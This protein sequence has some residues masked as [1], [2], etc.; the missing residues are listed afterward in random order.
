MAR[1]LQTDIYLD[2]MKGKPMAMV[3][4]D[5][6]VSD[7]FSVVVYNIY[8]AVNKKFYLYLDCYIPEETLVNHPNAELYKIWI[9]AGWMH[10]C[11]GAVID[12]KVIVRDIL[13]RSK[14]MKIKQIG[15]DAYKSQEIVNLLASA[16]SAN[17]A[18]PE[19]ILKPVP[20]NY[21]SFTSPVETFEMAAKSNPPR[22]AMDMNP[23]WPYCFGNCYLDIDKMEN[24]KPLKRMANC[25]IDAAI[26]ALMTFW[27]YN[28]YEF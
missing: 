12:G 16:I 24:K 2:A 22:V 9:N 18:A 17:G 4:L 26:G 10:V 11:E 14:L 19:K 21:A 13:R 8:S 15:Y 6:S 25:K 23:I 3:A 20:Q 5:L 7:D 27:M 1:S 28:N